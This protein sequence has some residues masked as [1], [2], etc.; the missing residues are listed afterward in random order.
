MTPELIAQI[1]PPST[2]DAAADAAAAAAF[3]WKTIPQGAATSIWS[4]VVAAADDVG[5]RYCEDCHVA[6]VVEASDARGGARAYALDA[7]RAEALW[8]KSEAMVG[9]HF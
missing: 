3:P 1:M 4:G 9:E 6:E 2:G 7:T 8:Q 5:G